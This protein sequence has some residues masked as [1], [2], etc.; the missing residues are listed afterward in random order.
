[1]NIEENQMILFLIVSLLKCVPNIL[2]EFMRKM[3]RII[4]LDIL[5]SLIYLVINN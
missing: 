5:F 3:E 4:P 1:M 2:P